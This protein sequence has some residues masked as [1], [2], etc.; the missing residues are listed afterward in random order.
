GIGSVLM[1]VAWRFP[2]A[3][4]V[5]IEAQEASARMARR[6]LAWNGAD[7]RALVKDGD[8]RDPSIVRERFDL[9]TG[10][11]PYFPPGEGI[12]P[13]HAQSA[14]CRFEHRGGAPDYCAAAARALGPGARFVMCAAALEEERVRAAAA[15]AGLGV[16]ARLFVVPREGKAPLVH[17]FTM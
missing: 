13:V 10:T 16:L 14:S 3:R 12:E 8:L 17:V 6:S 15:A 4:L 5:G 9:V 1:M 7:A 2:E 11:P